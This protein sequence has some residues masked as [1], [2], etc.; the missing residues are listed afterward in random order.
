MISKYEIFCY[1]YMVHMEEV[2]PHSYYEPSY[3][4]E[5]IYFVDAY[6]GV[7]A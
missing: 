2:A 5:S 3:R 1:D 7:Y 4:E 6:T